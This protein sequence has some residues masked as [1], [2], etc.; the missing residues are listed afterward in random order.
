MRAFVFPLGTRVRVRRG[1][2]PL[3]PSVVGREGLVM[4]LDEYREG[5]YGVILDGEEQVREFAEEELE[6][7]GGGL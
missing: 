3:D 5:R 4:H 6:A 7:P 2:F 1:P